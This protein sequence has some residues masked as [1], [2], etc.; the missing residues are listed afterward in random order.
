MITNKNISFRVLMSFAG[1]HFIWLGAYMSLI[2]VLYKVVGWTWLSIPWLP[3]SLIGTAVAFYVGFKNN[4]SYDRMWEARKIW[5]AMVNSSRSWGAMVAAYIQNNN[6]SHTEIQSIKTKLIYR[7]IAYLYTFREQLLVPTPWEHV[8]LKRHFGSVNVKRREKYG[9]GRFN[10]YL[11]EKQY[12]KYFGNAVEWDDAPNPATHII[13]L[14]SQHIE[15]LYRQGSLDLFKQIELQKTLNDFYDHQGKA[16]R[17]NKFPFPRQYANMSFVFTCLFIFFL[18]FGIVGE[19]AKLGEMDVWLI[20]PFGMLV[21]WIYVV[22]ELIGDY[23]ENPFEGL[24]TDVPM[25]S[26]CRTIE[27]D[28]LQMMDEEDIPEPIRSIDGVLM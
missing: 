17:I 6:L 11:T 21:G 23:S 16:E 22:M 14:Q 18:P 12:E 10:D 3:V 19:F 2:A 15:S 4:Q 8:S 25:L 26:I 7:H 27:I 28:L 24:A 9:V 13:F 5:G 1:G 20:I